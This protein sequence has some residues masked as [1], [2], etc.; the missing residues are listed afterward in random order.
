[1]TIRELARSAGV[2]LR[3]LRFYQSKRLIA[4]ARDGQARLY[5]HLDRERLGLILQGKRLGFT[6]GEIREMLANR[7]DLGNKDLPISRKKC[8]EQINLLEKQRCDIERA[9]VELRQIYTGMFRAGLHAQSST[10]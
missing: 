7:A 3:A 8:V 9:L 6:L 1:M 4:P 2:T 10:P 5:S